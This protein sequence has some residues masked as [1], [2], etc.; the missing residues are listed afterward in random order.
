MMMMMMILGVS[1]W[2]STSLENVSKKRF[3]EMVEI[4]NQTLILKLNQQVLLDHP[5]WLPQAQAGRM[6][7]SGVKWRILD[8]RDHSGMDHVFLTHACD[9]DHATQH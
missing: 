6:E 8:C 1:Q 5:R 7:W 9:V 2:F 3:T 4:L